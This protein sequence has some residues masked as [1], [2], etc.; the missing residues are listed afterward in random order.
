MKWTAAGKICTLS[1]DSRCQDFTFAYKK[2]TKGMKWTAAGEIC[3][4]SHNS[5]FAYRIVPKGTLE[6]ISVFCI[7]KLLKERT[8]FC[9]HMMKKN[10]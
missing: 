3:T 7:K 9:K 10:G 2:V 4:L 5:T 6:E 8:E 1:R